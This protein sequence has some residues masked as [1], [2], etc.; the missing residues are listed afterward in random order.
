M[1]ADNTSLSFS[2]KNILAMNE[3]VN[4]DLKCLKTWL[5]G[6]KLSINVAKTNSLVIGSRR[7][8]KD[9]QCPLT[10]KPSFG[11][12][13][14]EISILEHTKYFGVQVDQYMNW[15]NR[16]N[17]VIKKISRAL[18]MIRQTKTFLPLTSLQT[19]HKSI[20]EP[21]FRFCC[22]IWDS[23][24]VTVLC[25]LQML[26]NRPARIVIDNSYKRSASPIIEKLG[27]ITV[28]DLIETETLKM[29][30]KSK[31][32]VAPE[33]LNSMVINY[34]NLEI[35]SSACSQKSFSYR[36]AKLWNSLQAEVKKAKSI[37]QYVKSLENPTLIIS[38]LFF[39]GRCLCL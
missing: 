38:R 5:A 27:W 8:L 3:R 30:Y 14:G 34:P 13:G 31:N 10:I 7:Q 15:E 35:D 4:E 29:L 21:Y 36:R 26:Q 19:L 24:G 23:C 32:Q 28:N 9:T 37:T 11:I 22:P 25:K 20:V 18:G 33:Y 16:I 12:R 39:C 2:S 1:N 17:H 6:N